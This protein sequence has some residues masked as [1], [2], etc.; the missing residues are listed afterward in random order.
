MWIKTCY[1]HI[2]TICM[3][4]QLAIILDFSQT[5]AFTLHFKKMNHYI[6]PKEISLNIMP[7]I[8]FHVWAKMLHR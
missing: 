1:N 7:S 2:I 8:V 5:K 6:S 3:F 4:V